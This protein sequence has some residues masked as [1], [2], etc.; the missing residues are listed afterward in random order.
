MVNTS[1]IFHRG[2]VVALVLLTAFGIAAVLVFLPSQDPTAQPPLVVPPGIVLQHQHLVRGLA[3][4]PD[5]KTLATGGSSHDLP[6]E[7]KLW[8][9]FTG[10]ERTSLRASHNGFY[11]LAFAPDGRT[12]AATSIDQAVTLWDIATGKELLS[13]PVHI[14]DSVAIV[15]SP[16]GQTLAL[17]RWNERPSGVLMCRVPLDPDHSLA[18]GTSPVTF[19]ADSQRLVLWRLLRVSQPA[20]GG[21][22]QGQ[23][24]VTSST[25]DDLPAVQVQT[26]LVGRETQ[27]LRGHRNFVWALAGSSSVPG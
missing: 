6:G 26:V 8:D 4:A 21:L 2:P 15:L 27:T 18:S 5:G 20:G 14:A 17:T 7:I 22:A 10:V 12:L 11:S 24:I 1:L 23:G 9:P 3:F 16:D 13:I 25:H 19:S